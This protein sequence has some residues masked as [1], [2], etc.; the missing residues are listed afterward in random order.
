MVANLTRV[1]MYFNSKGEP[2]MQVFFK[3][4]TKQR[5][6]MPSHRTM[7]GARSVHDESNNIGELFRLRSVALVGGVE[8]YKEQVESGI[9]TAW[10]K[11]IDFEKSTRLQKLQNGVRVEVKVRQVSSCVLLTSEE[12][13]FCHQYTISINGQDPLSHG[14]SEPS[15]EDF[16]T[17]FSSLPNIKFYA[18]KT[19]DAR[20]F[21]VK[22]STDETI[23][24]KLNDVVYKSW[25]KL[26]DPNQLI[27]RGVN[28]K[29][30]IGRSKIETGLIGWANQTLCRVI[31]A[32]SVENSEP[33]LAQFALPSDQL[34]SSMLSNKDLPVYNEA[35][36]VKVKFMI[37]SEFNNISRLVEKAVLNE[38]HSQN[39]MMPLEK[40]LVSVEDSAENKDSDFKMIE[41]F[42]GVESTSFDVKD[43][44]QPSVESIQRSIRQVLPDSQFKS[45]EL[46]SSNVVY[47]FSN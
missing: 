40:I 1:E 16:S 18:A 15:S 37:K 36:Y 31:F 22:C 26:N 39:K 13:A 28:T 12:T 38:W 29:S 24:S 44:Q 11:V 21:Y 46:Q 30:I 14:L 23:E 34:I 33:N 35:K 25:V 19:L 3:I 4:I 5:R 42:V 9:E 8:E 45:A 6:L 47:Y 2:F 17:A 20:R 41:I 10:K 32:W 7:R 43:L 27:E